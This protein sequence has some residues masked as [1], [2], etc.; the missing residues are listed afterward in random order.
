[1]L[2]LFASANTRSI[3]LPAELADQLVAEAKRSRKPVVEIVREW[4]E[5][6]AD[7]RDAQRIMKRIK[8][9]KERL[10]PAAEVHEKL[11]L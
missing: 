11:G 1:M 3:E 5:D 9:G 2:K 7:V 10:I 6:R 4:L 8:D